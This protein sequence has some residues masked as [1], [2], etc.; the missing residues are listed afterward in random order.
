[1]ES[2]TGPVAQLLTYGQ[3]DISYSKPWPDY[4]DN[5]GLTT[6]NVPEL[7]RM[8]LDPIFNELDSEGPEVWAPIHAMRALGQLQAT[9]AIA[10]LIPVMTWEDDY[11]PG[12][13]PLV[14]GMM[15]EKAIAHL[16]DFI[17]DSEPDVWAKTAAVRGIA[18]IPTYHH[19]LRE[20]CVN[21]LKTE[22]HDLGNLD[23]ILMSYLVD[24]LIQLKATE[25][26]PEIEQAFATGK[27][28]ELLTGSWAQVQVDFGI[29]QQSDF[30]PEE[31]RPKIPESMKAIAKLS[32][33]IDRMPPPPKGFGVGS[34]PPSKKNKKNKKK[35]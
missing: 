12:S 20:T 19:E 2:Y 14:F 26:L 13:L 27:V 30:T 24:E 10:S 7:I 23:D 17:H 1:M 25:A 21:L 22:L 32:N 6:E 31:L 18:A 4:V 11:I 33:L 16:M 9:E 29:K 3:K 28:D 35:K 5:F 8:V 34:P 15:G